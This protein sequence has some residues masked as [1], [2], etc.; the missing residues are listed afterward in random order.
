M[1][2]FIA[3]GTW[4]IALTVI[5]LSFVLAIN[6]K[7]LTV[8]AETSEEHAVANQ[9]LGLSPFRDTQLDNSNPL[10]KIA[11]FFKGIFGSLFFNPPTNE[12]KVF[13]ESQSL[14]QAEVPSLP[15]ESP[16]D[17]NSQTQVKG[18]TEDLDALKKAAQNKL[19][20]I[21][22]GPTGVY[23]AGLPMFPENG[24]TKDTQCLAQ[25]AWFPQGV[26]PITGKDCGG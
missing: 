14:N 17:S 24:S 13:N 26:T 2:K 21:L 19:D 1:K 8:F 11:G 16:T 23:G 22:G 6:Y 12:D 7:P 4:Y 5:T 9:Q 3:Y 10:G 25:R 15:E 18:V 20:S